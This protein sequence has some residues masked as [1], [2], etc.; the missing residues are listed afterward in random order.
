MRIAQGQFSAG[1]NPQ[2][3]LKEILQLMTS[4]A[5][6]GAEL[7]VLPESS[8]Y[9]SNEPSSILASLAQ[10]LDG[11]FINGIAASARDLQLPVVVGTTEANPD[12]LPFN[13]LVA[14]DGSGAVVAIYRKVHLYD[15]FGYAESSGISPG[16]IRP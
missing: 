11:A 13:T 2:R 10:P 8:L 3:N 7:L 14:I 1:T 4:A 15:A 6:G 9:A 5:R 16:G 12:G